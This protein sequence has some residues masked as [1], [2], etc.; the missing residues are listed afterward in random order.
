M[1][2]YF[3]VGQGPIHV[4]FLKGLFQQGGWKAQV[5]SVFHLSRSPSL[6]LVLKSEARVG[7]SACGYA[8]QA[9]AAFLRSLCSMKPWEMQ[10]R[11][12]CT[13]QVQMVPKMV[14]KQMGQ[15]CCSVTGSAQ[16]YLLLSSVNYF[17]LL[18]T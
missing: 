2:S 5:L 4:D 18:L 1:S 7:H 8:I 9:F 10:A 6:Y 3:G 13:A 12:C 11:E 16:T 15:S 17:S 14:P